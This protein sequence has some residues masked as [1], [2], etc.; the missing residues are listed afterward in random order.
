MFVVLGA[1]LLVTLFGYVGLT[2]SQKDQTL[3]GDLVDIKSRD[4]AALSGLQ[5]GVNRLIQ[6]PVRFD[7]LLQRYL[8]DGKAKVKPR[9]WFD[10]T[11]TPLELVDDEPVWYSIGDGAGDQTAVKVQLLAL[12]LD[13]MMRKGAAGDSMDI[14]VTLECLARG[15][16]G[17]ERRSQATYRVHGIS[18]EMDGVSETVKI[19]EH[20]FFSAI[21]MSSYNMSIDATGGVYV[22]GSDSSW[23]NS[24]AGKVIRGNFKW[25]GDLMLNDSLTV[26]GD[27]YISG[28]IRT[29]SN[30]KLRFEG[31]VVVADGFKDMNMSTPLYVGG[32]LYLGDAVAGV[33]NQ[34][35]NNPGN[36]SIGQDLVWVSS[37]DKQW[38]FGI[39]VGGNMWIARNYEQV[40]PSRF[41]SLTVGRNL[42]LGDSSQARTIRIRL[43]NAAIGKSGIRV[44]GKVMQAYAN[45]IFEVEDANLQAGDSSFF[46]WSFGSTALPQ[47]AFRFSKYLSVMG[48]A[49]SN[50]QLNGS[51]WINPKTRLV[52]IPR[53]PPVFNYV[54]TSMAFTSAAQNPM[55]SLIVRAGRTD[56]VIS[57]MTDLDAIWS[58]AGLGANISIT[59]D[60]M[61]TLYA[62]MKKSGL[63]L[64]GYMVLRL[65][66]GL[67]VNIND[68]TQTNGFNGKMLMVV[69]GSY[70]ANGN[71]PRSQDSTNIQ[72][73]LIRNNGALKN[74]GWPNHGNFAGIFYWENPPCGTT[75]FKI[76]ENA[77]TPVKLWGSIII[78]GRV[79]EKWGDFPY[80]VAPCGSNPAR[81]T[82][83]SGRL[84]V[85]RDINIYIDIAV[86][87][88]YLF[89]PAD[90]AQGTSVGTRITIQRPVQRTRFIN[91]TSRPYLELVGMFR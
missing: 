37:N 22:A 50:V 58:K 8:D 78:G 45:S 34:A 15:R 20:A 54:D 89:K 52:T 44:G 57:A 40:F 39:R 38:R 25:D 62:F 85:I 68:G 70:D 55:D 74:W 72:V 46:D 71:W 83:N 23:Q 49:G 26:Q 65:K 53:I 73:L 64:N 81:L 41:D 1:I 2:L 51:T 86:N 13:T 47:D 28:A 59:P 77:K 29:N 56:Q 33:N 24:A 9:A 4:A 12:G 11:T 32:S 79:T 7:S 43:T 76:G 30:A 90:P 80:T 61:N 27:A 21:A 35:W 67:T 42:I 69:E 60:N 3:S 18:L 5:L 75:N 10:F 88:P 36:W 91:T 66:S 6:D 84:Q 14:Y 63:L 19:P 16:R 87:L 82:P 17:D 48:T 31:D